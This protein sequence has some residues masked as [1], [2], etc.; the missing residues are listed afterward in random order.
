MYVKYIIEENKKK[1]FELEDVRE[2]HRPNCQG[3]S[4]PTARPALCPDSLLRFCLIL[5]LY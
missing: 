3:E 5:E 1:V 2:E 4:N